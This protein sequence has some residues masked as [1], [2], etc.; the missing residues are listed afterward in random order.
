MLE[1][2]YSKANLTKVQV[3]ASDHRP[4]FVDSRQLVA[5]KPAA[6]SRYRFTLFKATLAQSHLQQARK[7][8]SNACQEEVEKQKRTL[9][10]QETWA[11]PSDG[12]RPT[13]VKPASVLFPAAV[14]SVFHFAAEVFHSLPLRKYSYD[15]KVTRTA[16][17]NLIPFLGRKAKSR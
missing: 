16:P 11:L 17:E 10:V 9:E 15:G 12:N 5:L 6:C 3:R 7:R 14:K 8:V 4:D 13:L 1:F 2:A